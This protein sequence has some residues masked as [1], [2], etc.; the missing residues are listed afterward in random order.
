M[1]KYRR[2]ISSS[3]SSPAPEILEYLARQPNAQDTIEGIVN[4]WVSDAHIRKRTI[5]AKTVVSSFGLVRFAKLNDCSRS[6]PRSVNFFAAKLR[7]SAP[8][9][10]KAE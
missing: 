1:M 2:P 6:L 10:A 4:W 9:T 5:V 7:K 3:L 8:R